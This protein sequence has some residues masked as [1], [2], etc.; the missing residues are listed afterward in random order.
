MQQ[1]EE[2]QGG[3]SRRKGGF[4]RKGFLKCMK[5]HQGL[6]YVREFQGDRIPY[7]GSYTHTEDETLGIKENSTP[8]KSKKVE[9]ET[10]DDE[11]I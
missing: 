2:A 1:S 6:E 11:N 8:A 10:R 7:V 4:E 9:K 5:V 3:S